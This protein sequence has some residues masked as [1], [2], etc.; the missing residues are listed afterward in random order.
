VLKI[1]KPKFI[2][3]S[4]DIFKKHGKTFKSLPHIQKIILFGNERIS[5][6]LLYND[7][8]TPINVNN[9]NV[10]VN[11]RLTRNIRYEEF[12]SVDVK[13][14]T[15]TAFILYSSGTTGLPK[16]V[17]LTHLNVISVCGL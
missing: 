2:V 9:D 12:E 3:C 1:S 10:I 8:T 4:K 17:M 13:G 16:G 5:D 11:T 14:Q 7:L 15:D 6:A